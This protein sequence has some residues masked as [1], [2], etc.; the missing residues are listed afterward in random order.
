[1]LVTIKKS[2]LRSRERL[3]V[4]SFLCKHGGEAGFNVCP[5]LQL[6]SGYKTLI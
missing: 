3:E 4:L 6:F 2:S 1:M 5:S